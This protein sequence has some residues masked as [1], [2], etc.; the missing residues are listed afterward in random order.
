MPLFSP[1]FFLD[2]AIQHRDGDG[3]EGGGGEEG[4]G[5]F[6]PL[7]VAFRILNC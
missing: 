3:K 7:L 1:F 4:L 6:I 5:V 2:T